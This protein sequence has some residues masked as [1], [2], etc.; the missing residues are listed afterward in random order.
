MRQEDKS[1]S[2]KTRGLGSL[3]NKHGRRVRESAF[4]VATSA[5][6]AS[7]HSKVKALSTI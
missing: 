7:A 6:H 4:C 5:L 2:L 1:A 3:K